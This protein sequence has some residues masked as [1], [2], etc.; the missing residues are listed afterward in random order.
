MTSPEKR[1]HPRSQYFLLNE[2]GHPLPVYA[3][4]AEQ[5]PSAIA[6]LLLDLS[7]GGVQVLTAAGDAPE[8][9]HYGL[10]VVHATTSD[11]V[12]ARLRV[13][14]VWQ[15][16]DGVNVRTGFAFTAPKETRAALGRELSEAPHHLL[17]CVLHP[18]VP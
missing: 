14:R 16:A 13:A 6:A 12:G 1:R 5:E 7:E 8:E 4:R 10:E 15:R 2:D 11:A 9:T 3:F 18:V 17:R